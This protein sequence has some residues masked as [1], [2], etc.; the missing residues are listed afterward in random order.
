MLQNFLLI[1]VI[2]DVLVFYGSLCNIKK[3]S[4]YRF[5]VNYFDHPPNY[6]SYRY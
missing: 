6:Q 5:N 4:K 2:T 3:N 1:Q